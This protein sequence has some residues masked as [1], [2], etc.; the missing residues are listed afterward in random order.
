MFP[1]GSLLQNASSASLTLGSS[2]L[3]HNI[4]PPT[5]PQTGHAVDVVILHS[6]DQLRSAQISSDQ[7]CRFVRDVSWHPM[8]FAHFVRDVSW[9]PMACAN[10]VRDVSW[11]PMA[12]EAKLAFWSREPIGS[13]ENSRVK[14]KITTSTACPVWGELG[15]AIL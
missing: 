13:H 1:M 12:F 5:S 9:H 15:G 11:H 2:R 14:C 4:T 8:A 6:P 7:P 3:C 10:F